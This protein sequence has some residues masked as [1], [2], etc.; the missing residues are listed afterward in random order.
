MPPTGIDH[1]V[2]AGPDSGTDRVRSTNGNHGMTEDCRQLSLF[3][4]LN[5][6]GSSSDECLLPDSAMRTRV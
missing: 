3:L 6:S 1:S 2:L 4:W 5:L